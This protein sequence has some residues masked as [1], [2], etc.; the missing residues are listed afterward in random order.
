[1]T[2]ATGR[3]LFIQLNIYALEQNLIEDQITLPD[4]FFFHFF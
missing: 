4:V 1:M 3:L 2:A